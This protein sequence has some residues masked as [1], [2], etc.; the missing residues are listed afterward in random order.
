M[1]ES[2]LNLKITYIKPVN[3]NNL[4]PRVSRGREE[5]GP[6]ERGWNVK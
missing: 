5:E 2:E 4:V 1:T 3:V 6:W